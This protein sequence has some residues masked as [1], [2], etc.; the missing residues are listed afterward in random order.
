MKTNPYVQ[1]NLLLN[2]YAQLITF[3][4]RT[5]LTNCSNERKNTSTETDRSKYDIFP[6]TDKI[7][8]ENSDFLTYLA[9]EN[10]RELNPST[11]ICK[12]LKVRIVQKKRGK[13]LTACPDITFIYNRPLYKR[14]NTK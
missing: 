6:D 9:K 5:A 2:I 4:K 14:K 8:I 3:A 10:W 7:L 12:E 1:T 11:R 13:Y